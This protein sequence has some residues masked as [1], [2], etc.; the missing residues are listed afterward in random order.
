MAIQ[1]AESVAPAI[2]W[3]DEIEKGFAGM[4]GGGDGAGVVARVFGTM[5][6]WMQEKTAPVFVIA[7]ANDISQLPPEMLR[8]GRFDEIF[9][10]DLP[11]PEEREA[12]FKIHLSKRGRKPDEFDLATFVD[13]TD[14]FSGAEIEQIIISALTEAFDCGSSLTSQHILESIRETH[15]LSETMSDHIEALRGWAQTR[16]R[17]ASSQRRSPAKGYTYEEEHDSFR[18]ILPKRD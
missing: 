2:L 12:I 10:V 9:F 8:K 6:T 15:P 4:R 3:I 13:K 11:F 7:T 1:V 5:I 14:L 18:L 16:A 17:I